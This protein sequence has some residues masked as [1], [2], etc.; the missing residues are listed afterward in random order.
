[1][2]IAD[3]GVIDERQHSLAPKWGM[4]EGDG[5]GSLRTLLSRSGGWL[6]RTGLGWGVTAMAISVPPLLLLVEVATRMTSATG[7]L[8]VAAIL[9]QVPIVVG[10]ITYQGCRRAR[11]RWAETAHD[12]LGFRAE[13][14]EAALDRERD[15]LHELRATVV[16]IT[17]SHRMLQERRDQLTGPTR[18]RLEQLQHAELER[19]ER[20]L[21]D[22]RPPAAPE[23][24][25]LGPVIDRLVESIRLRGHRV[26]WSGT[27]DRVWGWSDDVT[28]IVHVLLANAARHGGD[29]D[30]SVEVVTSEDTVDVRVRD[31]GTGVPPE[32]VPLIFERGVRRPG[33]PGQGIGLHIADRLAHEMGGELRHEPTASGAAFVLT[34]PALR[35]AAS[36]HARSA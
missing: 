16:G 15:R 32:L 27:D 30:V 5:P 21:Q 18:S 25:A 14:A 12:E 10:A 26:S 29:Q 17:M 8:V 2:H 19:L 34:L 24:V 6:R 9:A 3:V 31:H 33:S 23:A 35:G 4:S 36:C 20:I 13:L 28:E 11:E 22:E 1:M 7:R